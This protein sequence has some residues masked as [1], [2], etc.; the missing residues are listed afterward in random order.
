MSDSRSTTVSVHLNTSWCKSPA[1]VYSVKVLPRRESPC[2]DVLL[3]LSVEHRVRPIHSEKQTVLLPRVW[4]GH[5]ENNGPSE[6]ERER[7][8][9]RERGGGTKSKC[10]CDLVHGG[11]SHTKYHF[12]KYL[13]LQV[14]AAL[15]AVH[16]GESIPSTITGVIIRLNNEVHTQIHRREERRTIVSN[17]S[18]MYNWS[19]T[20]GTSFFFYFYIFFSKFLCLCVSEHHFL[21]PPAVLICTL[22]VCKW[23][24]FTEYSK[25]RSWFLQWVQMPREDQEN[26]MTHFLRALKYNNKINNSR[27]RR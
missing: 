21:A 2:R 25:T 3:I 12:Q 15:R 7:Q 24:F 4:S 11:H 26:L 20:S 23:S 16:G 27:R 10:R 9:V 19:T 8:R 22:S 14:P 6:K 5:K 18:N 17:S 1:A 13:S